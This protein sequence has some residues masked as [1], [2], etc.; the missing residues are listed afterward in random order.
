[1]EIRIKDFRTDLEKRQNA[2]DNLLKKAVIGTVA[3]IRFE[4]KVFK[5][6]KVESLD[7]NI[8]KLKIKGYK[9]GFDGDCLAFDTGLLHDAELVKIL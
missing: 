4:G 2:F 6:E 3:K 5:V 8:S 1:M 7:S 9:H